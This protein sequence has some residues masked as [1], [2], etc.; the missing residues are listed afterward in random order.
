[1]SKEVLS[2]VLIPVYTCQ[3]CRQ[4]ITLKGPPII[5]EAQEARNARVG[6]ALAAHLGKN[7]QD[8]MRTIFLTSPYLS[9]WLIFEKFDHNDPYIKSKS[10]E[11]RRKLRAMTKRINVTDELIEQQVQKMFSGPQQE[12]VIQLLKTLRDT[13]EEVQTPNTATSADQA[14]PLAADNEA[15]VFHAT[16]LSAYQWPNIKSPDKRQS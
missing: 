8:D 10:E 14:A 7:H 4:T 5:G 16:M 1:V 3:I 13:L 9:G 12:T 15:A 6:Q 2:P 11:F